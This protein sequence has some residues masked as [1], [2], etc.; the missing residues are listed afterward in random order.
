MFI[1]GAHITE[2]FYKENNIMQEYRVV[3]VRN[4]LCGMKNGPV[5]IYVN[6]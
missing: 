1:Q 4:A 3:L 5:K 2:V 6:F